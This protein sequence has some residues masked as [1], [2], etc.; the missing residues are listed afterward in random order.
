[1]RNEQTST[2][3]RKL[4]CTIIL[5]SALVLPLP[6]TA[7]TG[8]SGPWWPSPHGAGD[9]AGA[10]NYVTPEKILS[11]LQIPRTG[12][13]YELGHVY[14]ESMPQ[15]TSRPYYL[16]VVPAAPQASEDRN[17]VH[18]DYFTGYIGQMGTQ[19][20]ALS[21]QGRSLRMPDGS[22]EP[23][24][25]NGFTE[26]NLTGTNRGRGGVEA[27]GVEHMKPFITRGILIDIA[28]FRGVDTLGP[29]Y[30]VTLDDVR[31][32][33]ERQGMSEDTVEQ[34]DAVLLHYGW[35]V[36]WTNPS[37]YNDSRFGVGDNEGSPGIGPEVARWLASRKVSMVGADS[38]CV[39]IMPPTST[40][41][42]D[43]VHH[44]LFLEEGIG[45]L[46]NM[47]LNDV[48]RDGVY[49]FL[50]LNLTLRI[51]GATGSPVRPI[52]VR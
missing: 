23:V 8:P 26:Q 3:E 17:V 47:E 9:Q 5:L 11:A 15:Y 45:L 10:S 14:E 13:T 32:A 6:G 42:A 2:V 21:H 51:K 25:Y 19:F 44:I 52:A 28:G 20:D 43:N 27:L 16:N 38:C 35:S 1:M 49:E 4:R 18:G 37:R 33:L 46:E 31:G 41:I 29:R 7:Q 40:N 39:Q 34:G 50:F 48:A 24:F 36:H 22:I 12:Q 30:E